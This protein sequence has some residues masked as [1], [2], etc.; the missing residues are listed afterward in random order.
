MKK[1]FGI[2]LFLVGCGG[3][4]LGPEQ[5][6][7]DPDYWYYDHEDAAPMSPLDAMPAPQC[8]ASTVVLPPD[9]ATMSPPDASQP[10]AAQPDDCRHDHG[11][12][13]GFPHSWHW[14]YRPC[15]GRH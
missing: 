14:G 12:H 8:D 15:H 7:R 2:S 13:T 9:A 4:A 3:S 11:H 6:A 10:D 1:I 5:P